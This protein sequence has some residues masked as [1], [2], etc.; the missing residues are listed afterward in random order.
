MTINFPDYADLGL[1]HLSESTRYTWDYMLG[2][3]E[4]F[5]YYYNG[6]V[7]EEKVPVEQGIEDDAPLMYPVGLNLV[8][9]LCIAQADSMFGEY[10]DQPIQFG[11]RKD[12]DVSDDDK[13]AIDL[14]HRILERS[15]ASKTLWECELERNIFGGTALQIVPALDR[16]LYPY[17]KW[18]RVPYGSFFPIWH[19]EDP[20]VL[21]EVYTVNTMTAEQARI[22]YGYEAKT[23][24]VKRVER[25]SQT[26]HET[27]V[28]RVKISKYSGFNPYKVVPFVY[29]PRMRL[30]SWW[31]DGLAEE[32]I[33][34]QN[35]LNRVVADVSDAANYNAHPTRWGVNL[36]RDFNAQNYPLGPNSFWNLGRSITGN[37]DP[38]VGILEAK[39]AVSPEVFQ[40]V[41]FIYDW[42]RIAA[43]APPIAFGEDEGGSQ[44][45]G[46]TL[47]IRMWPLI[48]AL[49]R[50]R[51]YMDT[52][53]KQ[54]IYIS[55]CIL[56]QKKFPD[57]PV[58]AVE[59]LLKGDIVPHFYNIMP[60][61][62]AAIVDEVVKLLS[63]DPPSI[64]E[65][66]AQ[67]ILG[68]GTGEVGRIES[69]VSNRSLWKAD[70][71]KTEEPAVVKS[72]AN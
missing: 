1:G 7:F 64:S 29:I 26:E 5:S 35:E 45:S 49:R 34:I 19:P 53:I 38:S 72:P 31:G 59:K 57:V 15:Y 67:V 6:D 39:A 70:Q 25:W 52:G 9:M 23:E 20:D 18:Y 30:Q 66:T 10:E 37:P 50:S 8:K 28:D 24:L 40:Y 13:K 36:P 32:V 43:N 33:P 44:R 56:A 41:K 17:V 61:D 46:V 60:R 71:V 14:A 55:A 47:E 22:L 62:Q 65:E 4:N 63:T 16:R 12:A 27:W 69:M 42:G 21:L 68:R 2:R 58:R 11:A 3:A 54:A 51:A 48:K